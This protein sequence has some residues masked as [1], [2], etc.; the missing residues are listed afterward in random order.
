RHA[1]ADAAEQLALE[2]LD[3]LRRRVW[4]FAPRLEAYERHADIFAAAD[5]TETA[6]REHAFDFGTLADDLGDLVHHLVRARDRRAGWQR[7]DR[8]RVALV[9]FRHE[10]RRQFDEQ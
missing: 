2:L 3:Q 10:A 8:Q 9:L 5:E 6:D 7:H 4:S 1:V